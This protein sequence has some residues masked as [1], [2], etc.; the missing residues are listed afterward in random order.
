M[1]VLAILGVAAQASLIPVA[2]ASA[3]PGNK[4]P[5]TWAVSPAKA[6][7]ADGRPWVELELD[8]GATAG[9]HLALRNLGDREVTFSITAADGY[10]TS[11]GRFNM[12][13]SDARS[14]D[15]GT[16]ISV[17]KQVTVAAGA[18]AVV[19]FTVKVPANATPGDHA[20]GIAASIHSQ[21]TSKG[22]QVDVES[23]V[24]F[25]VMTRVKGVITPRLQLGSTAGYATSWNPFA[26][27]EATLDVVLEN[28]GNVRLRVGAASGTDPA[29]GAKDAGGSTTQAELLPGEKRTVSIQV[30]DV[31]PLGAVTL[32]VTVTQAVVETNGSVN[33]LPPILHNVTV[34]AIPWPQ[35]IVILALTLMAGGLLWG[36]MRQKKKVQQLVREARQLGRREAGFDRETI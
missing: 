4:S 35:L 17:K 19:P 16:W 26:P 7:G 30:R 14:V 8:P 3:E 5:V 23:R 10:F 15:S 27:G 9:D 13:P 11:T 12:L 29:A 18:T 34:W 6:S 25:R 21:G 36:R 32:P 31:W 22:S 2:A 20:A 24:G 28:T 33:G 1:S